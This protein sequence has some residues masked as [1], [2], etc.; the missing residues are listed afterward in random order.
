MPPGFG[1]KYHLFEK[2]KVECKQYNYHPYVKQKQFLAQQEC[3]RIA[4]SISHLSIDDKSQSVARE[5]TAAELETMDMGD[6]LL[7][8]EAR[9]NWLDSFRG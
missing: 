5:V 3:L 7:L 2:G 4:R 1:H 6:Y 9:S 8:R